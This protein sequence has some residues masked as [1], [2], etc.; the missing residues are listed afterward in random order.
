MLDPAINGFLNDRKEKWLKNQIKNNTYQEDKAE[1][2]RQADL[3]FSLC[4]WLPNAAK[5][6]KQLSAVSHPGKFCHPSAKISSVLAK[7]AKKSDGFLR[8]GN[9]EVTLDVFGNAAAMDVYK[10]LN[11]KLGDNET[12][13]AHLENNSSEIRKQLTITTVPFDEISQG[14]LSIKGDSHTATITSTLVK[15]VY[16]A[17]G[18]NY[19]LLSILTP[20]NI[21]YKL[22]GCID[23]LR[24]SEKAKEA[25]VEKRKNNYHSEGFSEIY[26]LHIIGFGGTKPQNI[27]ALNSQNGGKAYLLTSMPPELAPRNIQPP[28][29]NFFVNTIWLNAYKTDFQKLHTLLIGDVNN[30]HIRNKRDRI[31][32]NIVYQVFD[33]LWMVRSLDAGWSEAENYVKLPKYQKIWL[34]QL[35]EANRNE[36]TEWLNSVKNDF[37]RWFINAYIRILGKNAVSL[38]DEQLSYFKEIIDECEEALR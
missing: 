22:K 14:L 13:L 16:F 35:Y 15:Q 6:A 20:S 5:R 17:V 3:E 4:E 19:H 31:T 18:N 23:I 36:N 8:T 2:E 34:D 1:L 7:C 21:M 29:T 33:K 11:L 32:K 24:F 25:R 27:S 10:F 38:G 12:I 30:M 37:A 28:K 26:D 9:V